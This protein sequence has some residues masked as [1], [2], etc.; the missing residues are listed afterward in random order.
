[1]IFLIEYNRREGAIVTSLSFA[2]SARRQAE[3]LRLNL[4]LDLNK[5]GVDHEVVLL[6]AENEAALRLTHQ[7]YFEDLAQILKSGLEAN[8]AAKPA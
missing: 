4:E 8:A 2:N 1:M 5:R 7:R 6:D 3:A